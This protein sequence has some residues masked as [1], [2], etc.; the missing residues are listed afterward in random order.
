MLPPAWSFAESLAAAGPR[1]LAAPEAIVRAPAPERA[2]AAGTARRSESAPGP[3]RSHRLSPVASA[4][5]SWRYSTSKGRAP[6]PLGRI[7]VSDFA[8]A[9]GSRT[10][11][12]CRAAQLRNVFVSSR[13]PPGK[14][15]FSAFTYPDT[16]TSL[17]VQ[18]KLG[19]KFLTRI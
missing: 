8:H 10:R 6:K 17:G 1:R 19:D 12:P 2:E 9:A 5:T 15:V 4:P 14:S 18:T 7:S 3:R 16:T 13:C 11:L